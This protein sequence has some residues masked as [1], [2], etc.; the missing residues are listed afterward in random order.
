MPVFPDWQ[1]RLCVCAKGN[2]TAS[3][4]SPP[5]WA[6]VFIPKVA[7]NNN[8]IKISTHSISNQGFISHNT[9]WEQGLQPPVQL[10]YCTFPSSQSPFKECWILFLPLRLCPWAF[11]SSWLDFDLLLSSDGSES[12]FS[13]KI[14]TVKYFFF[15]YISKRNYMQLQ[16][17]DI[18]GV[19]RCHAENRNEVCLPRF[20]AMC[21]LLSFM[22][23]KITTTIRPK[24]RHVTRKTSKELPSLP[25]C[26]FGSFNVPENGQHCQQYLNHFCILLHWYC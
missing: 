5:Y 26:V 4:H 16:L 6:S 24:M 19:M 22:A 1:E 21:A 2:P 18:V 7:F 3:K 11:L 13:V 23:T 20:Q 9:F 14:K 12:S 15:Q 25:V 17:Y 8:H 10:F